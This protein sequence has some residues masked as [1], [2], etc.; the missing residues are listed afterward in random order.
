MLNAP[1]VVSDLSLIL[2]Q[3]RGAASPLCPCHRV[4]RE[5]SEP[6]R[7]HSDGIADG[8]IVRQSHGDISVLF[9]RDGLAICWL[10]GLIGEESQVTDGPDG[11]TGFPTESVQRNG[12]LG[13][14][15]HP[16]PPNLLRNLRGV[17]YLAALLYSSVDPGDRGL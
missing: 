10:D 16:E 12:L 7:P 5:K 11:R 15:A 17:N 13:W 6:P 14:L 9:G 1:G 4:P 3:G 2:Q 8:S